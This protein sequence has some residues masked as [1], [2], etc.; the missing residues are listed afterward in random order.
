MSRP[1]RRRPLKRGARRGRRRRALRRRRAVAAVAGC[2]LTLLWCAADILGGPTKTTW[3]TREI[4]NAIRWVESGDRPDARVPDGDDGL[5][6]GPYQIHRVYWRDAADFDP[7]L[8]GDYQ[9]CRRG[10]YA[11]RVIQ[12]YMRR[13][14][15][16][17]WAAGDA[18]RIARVH[19]GGPEGHLK[20][21][22]D[23]YWERV[24]ERLR[25]R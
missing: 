7:T 17:A 6:I 24:R 2:L 12:A 19:N 14:A 16:D 1:K 23:E 5:A 13:H 22:T 18:E 21:A 20:R 4:L 10:S 3:P 15:P 9:D 11:E 25:A 8:A